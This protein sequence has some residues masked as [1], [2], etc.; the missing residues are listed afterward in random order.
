MLR[1]N[2]LTATELA[3]VN[4]KVDF[5][6][7]DARAT[8]SDLEKLCDVAYKNLYYSVCVNPCNVKY[9]SGY[10]LKTLQGN[11]KIATVIGF[12]LGA[13]STDVKV[14]ETKTAL[15]DGADE[16]DVVINIGKAKNGDFDYVKKYADKVIMLDK[17][18]VAKGKP[19]EV[20]ESQIFKETFALE[21]RP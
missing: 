20:F 15:Q 6:L 17:A 18:V 14:F 16:I 12:P 9:V 10:I 11:L 1:K 8:E 2:S 3:D 5:T 7:L 13:N 4:S 19:E 21:G